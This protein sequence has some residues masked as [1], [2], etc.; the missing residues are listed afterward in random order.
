MDTK[1]H[2]PLKQLSP[3]DFAIIMATGIVSIAAHNANYVLIA[4]SLFYL[5]NLLYGIVWL[6]TLLK[7]FFYPRQLWADLYSH[8]S[9]LSFLSLV[10][11]TNVLAVQYIL[12]Y[13]N[14]QVAV[15]LWVVAIVWWV[16]LTYLIFSLLTIKEKKPNLAQG[17]NGTWLLAIVATQSVAVLTTFIM[18]YFS[19]SIHTE[20][21]FFAMSMWLWGGMQYIWMMALIF[22]RYNFVHMGPDELTPPYWIN[23]GAMAISTLSG[24]LLIEHSPEAAVLQ[25]LLPFL[26]GFTVFFRAS[27]TWWIP[28]LILLGIWRHFIKHYPVRYT[29]L[30]W[31]LVF[32]LGMYAVATDQLNHAMQFN[33]LE[34]FVQIATYAALISWLVTFYGLTHQ[35]IRWLRYR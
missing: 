24:S 31:G 21:S 23:M 25:S 1:Y 29:P 6:L 3:A 17:I 13:Q 4:K 27:A 32:P 22:W 12:F 19:T 34:P 20:L 35:V 30:F 28:L 14:Y 33:F 18:P 2:H 10:A 8:T 7:L 15:V 16:L 26:K 9:G 11:A 5:N